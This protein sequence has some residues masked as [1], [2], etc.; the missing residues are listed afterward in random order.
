MAET[1]IF[2][3]LYIRHFEIRRCGVAK[4]F[5]L[6]HEGSLPENIQVTSSNSQEAQNIPSD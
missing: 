2:R 4:S 3:S 5:R 6:W 1:G